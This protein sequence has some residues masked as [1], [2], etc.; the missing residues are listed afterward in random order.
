MKEI[1]KINIIEIILIFIVA[2]VLYSIDYLVKSDIS[3]LYY[4]VGMLIVK[5]F[6]QFKI[7]KMIVEIFNDMGSK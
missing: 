4:F 1:N 6:K 7:N 5:D 3:I 2:L